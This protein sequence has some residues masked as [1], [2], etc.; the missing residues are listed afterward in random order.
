MLGF[1]FKADVRRSTL[2]ADGRLMSCGRMLGMV[3]RIT[4]IF[5]IEHSYGLRCV[6]HVRRGSGQIPAAAPS[7]CIRNYWLTTNTDVVRAGTVNMPAASSN[8]A[9]CA[10]ASALA[11]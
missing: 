1:H 10:T 7:S 6:D 8:V 9:V 11:C 2:P 3:V 4:P 5:I